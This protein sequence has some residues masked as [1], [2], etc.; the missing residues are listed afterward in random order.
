MSSSISDRSLRADANLL[1]ISSRYGSLKPPA[2]VQLGNFALLGRSGPNDMCRIE[3]NRILQ[4]DA[5]F[6][7]GEDDDDEL[8]L[9]HYN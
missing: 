4:L 1:K 9:S 2:T 8:S 6:E 3:N 5:Q 7:G